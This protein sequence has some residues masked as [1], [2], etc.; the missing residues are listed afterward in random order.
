DAPTAT[1]WSAFWSRPARA[2][3]Y[4]AVVVV[5]AV[6]TMVGAGAMAPVGWGDGAA[7]AALAAAAVVSGELG[8]LA[9]GTRVERQRIHKGLS[10]WAFAAA[11]AVGPGLAGWVAAA[12]Y[13][14]AWARGVRITRWKWVGSW[15]IVTLAGL[16]G[17][18]AMAGLGGGPG[19]D[20]SRAAFAA[21][22]VA[23]A[24]FLAVESALLFGISRLNSE[25]D[26]VYLRAVLA[27]PTFYV[28]E[29]GVLASG[30]LVA[31]VF[32]SHPLH[33][34]L[35][36]PAILLI[37]RGLLHEPLRHEARHDAKTGLLN[38]E[39][40][41][42]A[43]A[44][45]LAACHRDGRPA[46]VLIVDVD[47]FK[48]VNDTW[49]HLAGDDVLA[50]AAEAIV[51]SVR[52]TDVIGRF[53]GDEFCALLS[54]GS[55]EEAAAAAERVCARIGRLRFATPELHVTA[56]VGV[57][58]ADGAVAG[59]DLPWLLATADRALYEAKTAGRGR[60]CVRAG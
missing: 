57:A 59:V 26:E 36:A 11:L 48:A 55:Y 20:A 15:A 3:L 58:V 30:A 16:A 45:A 17:H 27:G 13:A 12:A 10:A 33:L 41:R 18:A 28:V 50:R 23:L 24:V 39:A 37:Q 29:T 9:E 14:H 8:R 53:G 60:V 54:C 38:S 56:S 44:A 51:A 52:R 42:S 40:W 49:G 6:A 47:H 31:V 46:A 21:T 35:A 4:V 22:V 1:E 19:A 25:A 34:L 2:R 7:A 43:A 5:A 32:L